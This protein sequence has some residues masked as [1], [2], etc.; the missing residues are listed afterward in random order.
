MKKMWLYRYVIV[1]GQSAHDDVG[2][3]WETENG[4]STLSLICIRHC[5][6]SLFFQAVF[7]ETCSSVVR[8]ESILILE[9]Q[10]LNI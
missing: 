3:C 5:R 7:V 9:I 1:N 2:W 4:E 10:S 6:V 8:S